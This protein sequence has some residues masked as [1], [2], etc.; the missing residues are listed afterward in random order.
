MLCCW[1]TLLQA[2]PG[3]NA[4]RSAERAKPSGKNRANSSEAK[5]KKRS[6]G[7]D[8]TNSQPSPASDANINHGATASD[9]NRSS[10]KPGSEAGMSKQQL[11]LL[12]LGN[13]GLR[14]DLVQ[15]LQKLLHQTLQTIPNLQV[16]PAVEL[17]ILLEDP[18]FLSQGECDGSLLCAKRSGKALGAQQA[19]YGALA[20]F[21]QSFALNLRLLD[22]VSGKE[23]RKIK[24]NLSGSQDVLIPELRLAAYELIA[25][26]YILGS[27]VVQCP[28]QGAEI[29][30]DNQ[31]VGLS[32]LPEP[33]KGI[34]V[35]N[36]QL[37][38]RRLGFQDIKTSIKIRPFE[39][40]FYKLTVD[41]NSNA[42]GQAADLPATP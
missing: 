38:I 21:G 8:A 34:E 28:I 27:I 20:G 39:T 36:H 22:V 3:T 6:Q 23:L 35:G 40:T 1:P 31:L 41:P 4:S 12:P 14:E 10:S 17:D 19:V 9:A 32:P 42:P 24:K 7:S 2:A 11:V 5:S 25:P 15:S 29:H 33:I 18:N 13:L 37:L 30:L 26:Q 16:I